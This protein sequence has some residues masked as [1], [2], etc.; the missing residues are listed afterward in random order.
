MSFPLSAAFLHAGSLAA[1]LRSF[2]GRGTARP[3]PIHPFD[4]RYAVETDG[5]LYAP[6]LAAGHAHDLFNE[7]YY[8]TAPSLFAGAVACWRQTLTAGK[9]EDYTFIDLGC[10]KGRVLLLASELPFRSV[11]GIELNPRLVRIARRNLR[12]WLGSP[13]ACRRVTAERGDVL[14]LELPAGPVLLFLFNSFTAEVL[15]PLIERL[16]LAAFQRTA[17]IDLLYVHPDLARLVTRTLGMEPLCRTEI[18][19]SLEDTAADVFQVAS[20]AVAIYRIPP[21]LQRRGASGH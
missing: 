20:D 5:L 8:A 18:P 2:F 7:G 6:D 17:P 19:F 14:D 13:R 10:G 12:K 4:L 16:A 9:G 21:A 11:R 3:A 1:W 15:A